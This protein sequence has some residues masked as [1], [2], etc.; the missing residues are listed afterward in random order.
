MKATP[1]RTVNG[2][3]EGQLWVPPL[4]LGLVATALL[5]AYLP[6]IQWL[7]WSWINK[8]DYSHGFVV[9]LVSASIAWKKRE[10]LRALPTTP[11]GL[12]LP[13]VTVGLL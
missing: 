13:M 7:V 2:S 3:A 12:G 5:I 11:S 8:E 10:N 9:P 4:L 1:S 6:T